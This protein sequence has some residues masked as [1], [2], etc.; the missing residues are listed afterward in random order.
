M[1][2]EWETGDVHARVLV[3]NTEWMYVAHDRH[4]WRDLVNAEMNLR[5]P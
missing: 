3:G 5:V 2:R 1:L 4:R